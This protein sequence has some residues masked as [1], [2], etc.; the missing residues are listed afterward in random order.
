MSFIIVFFLNISLV[1]SSYI[2]SDFYYQLKLVEWFIEFDNNLFTVSVFVLLKYSSSSI[3][4]GFS[5]TTFN[6]SFDIGGRW[7]PPSRFVLMHLAFWLSSSYPRNSM[8]GFN[9]FYDN[10]RCYRETEVCLTETL[11]W[12]IN[13]VIYM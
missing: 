4:K 1:H 10:S 2:Y 5:K 6:S 9:S 11:K 3:V 12:R 7:Y 8:Q 13:S